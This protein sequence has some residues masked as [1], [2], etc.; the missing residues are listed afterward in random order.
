MECK[1]KFS[2]DDITGLITYLTVAEYVRDPLSPDGPKLPRDEMKEVLQFSEVI[3][4]NKPY[5][6]V[7]GKS[8]GDR[9]TNARQHIVGCESCIRFYKE[10]ILAVA[11]MVGISRRNPQNDDSSPDDTG[12]LE[13]DLKALDMGLLDILY[14]H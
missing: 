5:A 1:L 2:L 4:E 14:E 9:Y 8:Y 11:G 7:F 12:S 13:E 10:E 6:D 3:D